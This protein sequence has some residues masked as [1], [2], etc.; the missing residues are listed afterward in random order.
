MKFQLTITPS[1]KPTN[2]LLLVPTAAAPA[3]LVAFTCATPATAALRTDVQGIAV[4]AERD[5]R[6][7]V[8]TVVVERD[9]AAMAHVDGFAAAGTAWGSQTWSPPL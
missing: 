4:R 3:A 5:D 7:G 9:R 1:I 8:T 6:A 2:G